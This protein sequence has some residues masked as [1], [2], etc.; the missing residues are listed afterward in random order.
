MQPFIRKV[1]N[2]EAEGLIPD[3]PGL[4]ILSPMETRFVLTS[5]KIILTCK[6]FNHF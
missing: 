3:L 6:R 5:Q 2:I 4:K 1:G